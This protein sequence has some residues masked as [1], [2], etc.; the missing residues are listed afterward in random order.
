L[1]NLGIKDPLED[2]DV[3]RRIILKCVLK[4][5]EWEGVDWIHL[6]QE[7]EQWPAVVDALVDFRF[8]LVE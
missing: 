3:G 7:K 4:K 5:R 6:P 1:E 2:L 8:S